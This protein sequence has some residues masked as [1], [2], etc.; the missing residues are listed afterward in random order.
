MFAKHASIVTDN[1]DEARSQIDPDSR[2]KPDM[3]TLHADVIFLAVLLLLLPCSRSRLRSTAAWSPT[4][5]RRILVFGLDLG[6]TR[7]RSAY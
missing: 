1:G 3:V 7:Q 6:K 5:V 4:T 2:P